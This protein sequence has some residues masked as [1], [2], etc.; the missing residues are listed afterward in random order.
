MSLI[1]FILNL[2]GLLLWISWRA[3]PFDPLAKTR[4]AT[5]PGTIRPAEPVRVRPWHFLAVLALLLLVRPLLYRFIGPSL[6]WTPSIKLGAISVAFRSDDF[7]RMLF[8]S[9][10]SFT[11]MLMLFY[12][13]LLFLS[14]CMGRGSESDVCSQFVRIQ[15]GKIHG[16]SVFR[17]LSL[18]FIVALLIWLLPGTLL[19]AMKL[20]PP[21]QSWLHRIEQGI[22]LG[23]GTYLV[24]KYVI[25]AVLGLHLLNTYVYLGAHPFWRFITTLGQRL[26]AP[27]RGLPLLVG[28][29]DFA[30]VVMIALVFVVA[31]FVEN[32]LGA[33]HKFGLSWLFSRLPL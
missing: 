27:M 23:L 16:W 33:Q 28:K 2:A 11:H 18:P 29:V 12:L 15:L 1:D 3:V 9:F 19:S 17:R 31:E 13:W 32:G 14:L 6:D 8:F 21:A 5:L 20:V 7:W 4:P 26:L 30:P 10:A 25:G 22:V 24:W